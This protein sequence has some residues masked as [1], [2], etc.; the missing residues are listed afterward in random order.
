MV[1]V[2]A[3]AALALETG[4]RHLLFPVEFERDLRPLLNP[5]LTPVAWIL[6]LLAGAAALGGLALQRRASSRR[7]GLLP[8]EAT[9]QQRYTQ[10]FAVFLLSSSLPQL[11]SIVATMTYMFGADLAPVLVGIGLCTVG[12]LAQAARV[13]RL[14]GPSA[15]GR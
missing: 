5:Y 3:P 1:I 9:P 12:V 4:L 13:S 2:A 8:P 14:A 10:V 7:L 6:G 15:E 11:P